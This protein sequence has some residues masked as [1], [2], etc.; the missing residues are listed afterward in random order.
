MAAWPMILDIPKSECSRILRR[1][2]LMAYASCI[3]VLRAQGPLTKEKRLAIENLRKILH[4]K[5]DQHKTEVR[6][7]V[8]DEMLTT[9]AE[10]LYGANTELDW[11]VEGRRLVPLVKRLEPITAYTPI[12]NEVAEMTHIIN[13]SLP[14]PREPSRSPTPETDDA[15]ETMEEMEQAAP[16]PQPPPPPPPPQPVVPP[17]VQMPIKVLQTLHPTP[18]AAAAPVLP[19]HT[20]TVKV[21][22]AATRK[23]RILSSEHTT[24]NIPPPSKIP[25]IPP[26]STSS[27]TVSIPVGMSSP[28]TRL[29]NIPTAIRPSTSTASPKVLVV[30]S[31][32][33]SSTP[34]LLHRSLSVPM[35]KTVKSIGT[36]LMSTSSS[37]STS[38]YQGSLGAP[39]LSA[40]RIRPK[41][42]APPTVL[43][44]GRA[45]PIVIAQNLPGPSGM[46][47]RPPPMV[48]TKPTLQPVHVKQDASG[49]KVISGSHKI[50]PKPPT[51]SVT[52]GVNRVVSIASAPRINPVVTGSPQAI[53]SAPGTNQ[54]TVHYITR[55]LP[56]SMPSSVKPLTLNFPTAPNVQPKQNVILV[57]KGGSGGLASVPSQ[58]NI[59]VSGPGR[60]VIQGTPNPPSAKMASS[61]DPTSSLA[62]LNLPHGSRQGNVFV[63]DLSQE[64][65]NKNSSLSEFL[66]TAG[67]LTKPNKLE[68]VEDQHIVKE[69]V[70]TPGPSET[71]TVVKETQAKPVVAP[72]SKLKTKIL[73]AVPTR[74]KTQEPSEYS[75]KLVSGRASVESAS[76]MV[77]AKVEVAPKKGAKE[78]P[79]IEVKLQPS[80]KPKQP[81]VSLESEKII[82]NLIEQVVEKSGT[83]EAT[84]S[85]AKPVVKVAS[86]DSL[87]EFLTFK[88]TESGVTSNKVIAILQD[89]PSV[90]VEISA[91]LPNI[92]N[93][94]EV[95]SVQG[96]KK[97]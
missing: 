34:S 26:T 76:P 64:Q 48:Q 29:P 40:P 6:R 42:M 81:D 56:T 71:K 54:P 9:I 68:G 4:I 67:I 74:A 27:R 87:Q 2:E 17:P 63:L 18:A 32:Q 20:H 92:D 52:S 88:K 5:T 8:N 19:P 12:A 58:G 21:E 61:G 55:T 7:V 73:R 77:Q 10:K 45:G 44:K 15:E 13:A 65:I 89:E 50:T 70:P 97:T 95:K 94:V 78:P 14:P 31:S 57:K 25:Y 86:E 1:M 3:S 90:N 84:P 16:P 46:Q 53:V 72:P 28:S 75:I 47:L 41:S 96:D 24:Q 38:S 66:Q 35:V 51:V 79:K 91:G 62:Y 36:G 59:A 33:S 23:R 60:V 37:P 85:A 39:L 30:S 49:V 80:I 83:P 43:P 82:V 93:T 69:I 22:K 11:A